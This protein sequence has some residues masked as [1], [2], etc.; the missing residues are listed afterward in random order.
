M[1][2]SIDVVFG[3]SLCNALGSINMD[4]HEGEVPVHRVRREP[5]CKYPSFLDFLLR[6]ILATDKV[7]NNIGVTDALFNRLSVS[8][9]VFLSTAQLARATECH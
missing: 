5:F 4:I 6:R 2:E 7:V 3:D 9:V 8:Q 1:D